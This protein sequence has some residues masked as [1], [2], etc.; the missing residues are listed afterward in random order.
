M[1]L[2]Y[3]ILLAILPYS[4]IAQDNTIKIYRGKA[5]ELMT[6]ARQLYRLERSSWMGT[7]KLMEE[8][9]GLIP[10]ESAKFR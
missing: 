2:K 5:D 6:K 9:R 8:T 1:L 7:D 4:A 3:W 10:E